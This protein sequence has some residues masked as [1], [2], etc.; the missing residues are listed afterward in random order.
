MEV[1]ALEG[2]AKVGKTDTLV[3]LKRLLQNKYPKHQQQELVNDGEDVAVILTLNDGSKVGL[4]S[5]DDERLETTLKAFEKENCDVIFCVC[6]SRGK[7]KDAVKAM[8]PTYQITFIKKELT[9]AKHRLIDIP[10]TVN[11]AQA[12]AMLNTAG[13]WVVYRG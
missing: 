13:L 1:F 3:E 5:F 6:K 12:K 4:E 11:I 8:S 10:K 2:K 7:T 9:E